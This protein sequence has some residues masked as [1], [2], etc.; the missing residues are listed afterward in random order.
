MS[1]K[2]HVCPFVSRP[3]ETATEHIWISDDILNRAL[4]NFTLCRVQL[5]Y[6]SSTP[7]PL[8]AR[9]R[10]TKRRLMSIAQAGEGRA[11]DVGFLAGLKGLEQRGCQWQAPNSPA[12]QIP[13][14]KKDGNELL[15]NFKNSKR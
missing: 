5:R 1:W 10:A 3:L 12:S 14:E 8:E 2:R 11:I 15:P 4:H 13:S 7:G 6:G 9:K